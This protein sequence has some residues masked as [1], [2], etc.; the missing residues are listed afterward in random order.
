MKKM[1]LFE[2]INAGYIKPR[3]TEEYHFLLSS[4]D[5]E[6]K[7]ERNDF[8]YSNRFVCFLDMLGCKSL[9][10]ES[11]SSKKALEKVKLIVSTFE[12]IEH[13]YEEPHWHNRFTFPI[14]KGEYT[15]DYCM[16]EENIETNMSLFSDSIII[17]YE[18]VDSGLFLDW[19]RQFYQVFNDLC[20]LQFNFALKGIFLR[21]GLSYGKIYHKKNLCFGPA[22]I[23]AVNLEKDYAKYPCIA[24]DNTII[25]KFHKDMKSDIEDDYCPGYKFPHK[26]KDFAYELCLNYFVRTDSFKQKQ[27]D[28]PTYMIDWLTSCFIASDYNITKMRQAILIELKKNYKKEI[29][30]KYQWLARYYNWAIYFDDGHSDMK[31]KNI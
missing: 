4:E 29:R 25:E 31:I 3:Q 24:I 22:L 14:R 16:S 10:Y 26:I 9:V 5:R 8:K 2:K 6:K 20:R 1:E 7:D 11:E 15:K 17:S 30:E 19:Y 12:E 28:M 18:L 13:L 21:G 27:D 23:N